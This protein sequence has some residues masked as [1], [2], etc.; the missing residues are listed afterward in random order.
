MKAFLS[1]VLLACTTILLA[2]TQSG[3]PRPSPPVAPATAIVDL[4][5]FDGAHAIWGATGQDARGHIWF[6]VT[7]EGIVTKSAHLLD[8]D[9]ASGRTIDRGNVIDELRRAGLA[10]PGEQQ[11]KIHSKIIPGAADDVY[12]AS[13]DEDGEDENGSRL[14]TWGGHLWRMNL[15]TSRWEHLLRT[16]EALIAVG[17][18]GRFVY[19]LGYFGHVL[20]QY[21]TQLGTSARVGVG[22]VDGHISRNVLVDSR[23]HAYVPRL[24]RLP[25]ATAT[26]G[27][28]VTIVEFGPDLREIKETFVLTDR[29][30][31]HGTTG[32]HGIT[33]L[34]TMNDGTIWFTTDSGYLFHIVPP[35]AQGTTPSEEPAQVVPVG[36]MHPRGTSYAASLF[37]DDGATTLSSAARR[38]GEPWEWVKCRVPSRACTVFPLAVA[39]KDLNTALLYGSGTRDA[40]GRHYLVGIL[41]YRPF[42]MSVRGE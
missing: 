8:Y 12:F 11:A 25:G 22:S 6:G 42:A 27:M 34:Q 17:R 4:P 14:P 18:G 23:G 28:R 33:G 13:M 31:G 38:P 30:L 9:P 35:A 3:A 36:W 37:T 5:Y 26:T 16:P 1:L 24:K 39:G 20:Y 21:D 2:D 41:A 29:Y 7:T 32:S 10:R 40:Q 15:A 19:A